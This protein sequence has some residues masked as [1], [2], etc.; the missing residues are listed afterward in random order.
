MNK[1]EEERKKKRQVFNEDHSGMDVT[2]LILF[3]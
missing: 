1:K 3:V 2:S